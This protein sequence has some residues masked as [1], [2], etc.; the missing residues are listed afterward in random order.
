MKFCV[1]VASSGLTQL[2]NNILITLRT[3]TKR[4]MPL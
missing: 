1:E 3:T 4:K 2:V